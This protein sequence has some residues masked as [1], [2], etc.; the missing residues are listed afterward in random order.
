MVLELYQLKALSE[1]G[2]EGGREREKLICIMNA[3]YAPVN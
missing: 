3:E 1:E 2:W